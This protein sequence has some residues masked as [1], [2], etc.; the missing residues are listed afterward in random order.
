MD[1]EFMK[2]AIMAPLVAQKE[3]ESL[4]DAAESFHLLNKQLEKEL[5]KDY[6]ITSEELKKT[7][8]SIAHKRL[9]GHLE[10]LSKADED[11]KE[12]M[13]N[14]KSVAEVLK[15]MKAEYDPIFKIKKDGVVVKEISFD[16]FG[17]GTPE[18][19]VVSKK[20]THSEITTTEDADAEIER[21][22]AEK[23]KRDNKS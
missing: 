19:D 9:K 12:P 1:S 10:S 11:E 23:K 17:S 3:L 7:F 21:Y 15:I 5:G 2:R 18:I 13:L 16:V 6:S 14:E 20:N 4:R 8:V 22:L